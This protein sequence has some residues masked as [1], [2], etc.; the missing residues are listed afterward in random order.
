MVSE[1]SAQPGRPRIN[2]ESTMARF[3]EGTISRIKAV[4]RDGEKQADFIRNTIELEL[5]RREGPRVGGP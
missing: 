4:L 2:S 3:P 5:R 1:K